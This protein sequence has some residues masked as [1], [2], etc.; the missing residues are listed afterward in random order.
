MRKVAVIAALATAVAAA[1]WPE[2]LLAPSHP[3]LVPDEPILVTRDSLAL[4]GGC[5]PREVAALLLRFVDAFN[6]GDRAALERLFPTR[7]PPGRAS[8]PAGTAF[9]WY[10]ATDGKRHVALYDLKDLFPYFARRHRQGEQMRLLSVDMGPSSRAKAV[11]IGYA[12]QREADDLPAALGAFA[13]G[14]GEIDCVRKRIYVWSMAQDG[15]QEPSTACPRPEAWTPAGP[16]LACSRSGRAPSAQALAPGFAVGETPVRLP[17]RC[18]PGPVRAK[19]VSMLRAFNLGE[20]DAFARQFARN[21]D[22]HPYSATIALA[23]VGRAAISEFVSARRGAGDG[24]SAVALGP[25]L[26]R[27]NLPERAV[28]ALRLRVSRRQLVWADGAAKLVVDCR[29]GAVARWV[30]PG[31]WPPG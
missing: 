1:V 14:K 28:Y 29:S 31:I 18:R 8:E 16:V 20:G 27:V 25:P 22:F 19:V 17:T 23:L 15:L 12:L 13:H 21:G 9:R 2:R 5:S 30:G 7:D 4:S 6:R 10:S 3:E 11:G 26:G 24:W